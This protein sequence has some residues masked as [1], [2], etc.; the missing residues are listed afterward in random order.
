MQILTV[1]IVKVNI[2]RTLKKTKQCRINKVR[3]NFLQR[4]LLPTNRDLLNPSVTINS[5]I[6]Y[7]ERRK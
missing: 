5:T 2:L 6:S 7:V 1:L 3:E 4:F